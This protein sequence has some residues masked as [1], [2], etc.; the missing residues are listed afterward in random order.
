MRNTGTGEPLATAT[1]LVPVEIEISDG[2]VLVPSLD[3]DVT[4]ADRASAA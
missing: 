3:A 4:P 2:R 1:R